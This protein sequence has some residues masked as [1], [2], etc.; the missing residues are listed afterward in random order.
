MNLKIL[1]FVFNN[2]LDLIEGFS[3]NDEI[4]QLIFQLVIDA[5]KKK[6]LKIFKRKKK[7]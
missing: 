6:N 5:Q 4:N 7:L 2:V 1:N 3:K